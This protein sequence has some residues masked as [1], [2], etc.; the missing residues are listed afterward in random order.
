MRFA[1]WLGHRPMLPLKHFFAAAL[2]LLA[3]LSPLSAQEPQEL[4]PPKVEA[5]VI[6]GAANFGEDLPHGFVGG[7]VRFYVTKRLS[8]EPEYLYLRHSKDDQDQLFQPNVAYDF[9]DPRK[10]FV[11]YGIAGVGVL[12]HK[13]RFLGND[14]VTGAPV[15]FDTSFTTWTASVG[16]GVKIFLTDR[17]FVAPEVRVGREPSVRGTINVGYVFAGRR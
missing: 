15:L 7:A 11:V 17:F 6:A 14:F 10:R 3:A 8:I 4:T 12:R 1:N 9:S 2:F 13:G 5:K 16:G